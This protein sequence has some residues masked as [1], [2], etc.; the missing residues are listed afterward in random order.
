MWP[1]RLTALLSLALLLFPA[2]S[3]ADADKSPVR[4]YYE[5]QADDGYAFFADND[6]AFP[7]F[8]HVDFT[9]LTGFKTD[10]A[11]PFEATIPPG[12]QRV[13]LFKLSPNGDG[14]GRFAYSWFNVKGDPLTVR[15]D[16]AFPYI[17]PFEHGQKFK[18][19]QGFNGHFTH[20]GQNQFALDFNLPEGSPVYAARAGVVSDVKADS[21]AGG[22]GPEYNDSANYVMVMHSDG[23][24]GN[25]VHLRQRGA[26]VKVGD[27]V[28]A[29]ELI[30]YSG[31]TGQSSGPHLHFDVRV[32]TRQG[33]TQSIPIQ[34]LNY[35]GKLIVPQEG[36]YYYSLHPGRPSFPVILGRLLR[37]D[38]FKSYV[39]SPPSDKV[40]IRTEQVDD[41][42]VLFVSNP[43]KYP[44]QAE[45]K[46]DL[47]NMASSVG[48]PV[49]IRLPAKTE[50]FLTILNAVNPVESYSFDASL[51][52]GP[53]R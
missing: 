50:L 2:A 25:Y 29:G 13:Q 18:V 8:V 6:R 23:T 44:L 5:A 15:P 32:P 31:N 51:S 24:F 7:S 3:Y 34:M 14:K 28:Q 17:F 45:V 38:D 10:A 39:A 47:V 30:G 26:V 4:V 35:D 12:A 43:N 21:N 37:N 11:L 41:T 40:N 19:V 22:P 16:S 53:S 9:T 49:S 52:T 27:R 36:L 1:Q 48:N 33:T 46:L 42:V 20:F